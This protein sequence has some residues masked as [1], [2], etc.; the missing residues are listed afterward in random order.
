MAEGSVTQAGIEELRTLYREF[1]A[2]V[3]AV[4]L[5]TARAT[6]N[7]MVVQV[8]T[9]LQQPQPAVKRGPSRLNGAIQIDIV[10]DVPNKA[11]LVE[12]Q[13]ASR[14]P[15]NLILWIEYGNIRQRARPVMAPAARAV[16]TQYDRDFAAAMD[17]LCRELSS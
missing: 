2:R 17:G 5:R 15:A 14:Y 6:A 8:R 1:P 4:A 7:A 12:A 11:V 16:A 3:D 13:A 9:R 10:D